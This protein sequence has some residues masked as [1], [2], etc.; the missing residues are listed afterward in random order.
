MKKKTTAG[1][2]LL[3]TLYTAPA[4]CIMQPP[5]LLHFTHF[6]FSLQ[7]LV[8]LL[9][10]LVLV[11]YVW[12]RW[13]FTWFVRLHKPFLYTLSRDGFLAINKVRVP[14]LPFSLFSHFLSLSRLPNTPLRMTTQRMVGLASS[15][16]KRTTTGQ[17]YAGNA[18]SSVFNALIFGYL[19]SYFSL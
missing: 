15:S 12:I 14:F 4:L 10:T 1:K 3:R 9:S 6:S 13:Y 2:L 8:F 19:C 5:V 18:R 17:R 7:F 16:M 11:T